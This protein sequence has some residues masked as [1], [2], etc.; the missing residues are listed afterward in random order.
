MGIFMM[1]F[2]YKI[3]GHI[4]KRIKKKFGLFH[5]NKKSRKNIVK[6][7]IFKINYNGMMQNDNIF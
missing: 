3:M 5:E 7:R 4:I 1:H 2:D 6:K